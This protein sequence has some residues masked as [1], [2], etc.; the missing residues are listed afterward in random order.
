VTAPARLSQWEQHAVSEHPV[1]EWSRV[2]ANRPE[3]TS[4]L[5]KRTTVQRILTGEK[6]LAELSAALDR[7]AASPVHRRLHRQWIGHPASA[8]RWSSSATGA[9]QEAR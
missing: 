7:V 9:R 6:T 3:F 1:K 5:A 8:V 2:A 4:S